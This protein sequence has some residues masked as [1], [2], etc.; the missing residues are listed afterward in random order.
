MNRV[1]R[2]HLKTRRP[3][4]LGFTLVEM[5]VATA[6]VVV[7]MLLFA[8]VFQTA[9]GLISNQKGMAELD[10]NVRTMTT[11]LRGDIGQRTFRDIVPFPSGPGVDT[12]THPEL[13]PLRRGF[14]YIA[15]NDFDNPADDVLHLTIKVDEGEVHQGAAQLPF[16]GKA[17]LLRRPQNA[18]PPGPLNSAIDTLVERNNYLYGTNTQ[19]SSLNQPEFDDGQLTINGTGSSRYA[20]VCWFLRNGTLYRRMML[21]RE[22][23]VTNPG[24]TEQPEDANKNRMIAADA[25]FLGSYTAANLP[26]IPDSNGSYWQ[27]A[28]GRFWYDFDYSAFHDPVA[29]G[30]NGLTFHTVTD[31]LDNS[32]SSK[33]LGAFPGIPPSLGIPCL[34]FGNSIRR[35]KPTNNAAVPPREFLVGTSPG[36]YNPATFIGRFTLQET[37][38]S[39]F[40]YPSIDPGA[41]GGPFQDSTVLTLGANGLVS[42]YSNQAGRRGEDIVMTNVHS[43]DIQVWD[44][45]LSIPAWVN[46]GNNSGAGYYSASANKNRAT[47]GNRYDTWNPNLDF[48]LSGNPP[49]RPVPVNPVDVNGDGTITNA[50]LDFGSVNEVPLKAIRI[51]IRFYDQGSDQMR[52]M[53]FTFPLAD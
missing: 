36:N 32:T 50:D 51:H 20:E 53:T 25:T 14:F 49:Y 52:D 11:L 16:S 42:Q 31:A 37:A 40:T 46:L 44:D 4:P 8:Q 33:S 28:V 45:G 22:P 24:G 7:M 29:F 30:G 47:Y 2:R 19:P 34:R 6:L 43:F 23:Y 5:L 17:V 48:N 38:H 26:P 18:T 35:A 41:T 27:D 39:N 10:Q 3:E 9:S 12:N 15:E 1:S 21:I 13:M